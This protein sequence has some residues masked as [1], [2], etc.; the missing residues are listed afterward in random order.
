VNVQYIYQDSSIPDKSRFENWVNAALNNNTDNAELTIRVVDEE[1]GTAL[2]ETWRDGNG[3]T[4][5][6]SFPTEGLD[7]IE[8]GLLGDI[9]ICAPVVQKEALEQEK[10]QESHWAHMVIHGTL[11][12]IGYDHNNDKEADE[13]ESLEI[14]ILKDLGYTN[15]YI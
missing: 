8:P 11:H 13:M 14:N 1:E 6:L 4:N 10:N 12:L 15:P 9:V 5:V 7:E 3:P 2:N